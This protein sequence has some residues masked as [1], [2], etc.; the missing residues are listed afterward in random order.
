MKSY[1]GNT[2]HLSGPGVNPHWNV[3][4]G[5]ESLQGITKGVMLLIE[6]L[7]NQIARRDKGEH[8]LPDIIGIAECATMVTAYAAEI[9]I[10]T[11]IAQTK[12]KQKPL[13]SHD[14]L[15]LFDQ[16]DQD[17]QKKVQN[18]FKTMTPIGEPNWRN[19]N[20]N[21]RQTIDIGRN[22]FVD[23]RYRAENKEVKNGVPKALINVVVAVRKVTLDL[24]NDANDIH[25]F[26][27]NQNIHEDAYT[28]FY[29]G[30]ACA[31]RANEASTPEEKQWQYEEAITHFTTAI[32][33]KPDSAEAY[34]NRGIAYYKKNDFD[35]AI[36]DFVKAIQLKPDSAEAYYNRGNTYTIFN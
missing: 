32:K 9:A 5:L 13:E 4:T 19:A 1:L 12:P 15:K 29:R 31:N 26:I 3:H 11:L 25:G 7:D 8:P 34:I 27:R 6:E 24:V 10:K 21:I 20:E 30:F 16:L 33:L 17:I 23:W 22:N 36:K 14:L 28:H 2:I 18:T 35:N